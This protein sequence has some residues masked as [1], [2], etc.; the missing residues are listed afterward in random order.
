[1]ITLHRPPRYH[2]T[3]V[4]VALL[5]GTLALAGC[6]AADPTA[7][8]GLTAAPRPDG[9][10]MDRVAVCHYDADAGTFHLITIAAPALPA[11][12]RH[13]DGLPDGAVPGPE[14]YVFDEAC[15][16]I[17][18]AATCPCS[19]EDLG[20][21]GE[22]GTIREVGFGSGSRL[23]SL[24]ISGNLL[25]ITFSSYSE[26]GGTCSIAP[27]GIPDELKGPFYSVAVAET[28]RLVLY[29]LSDGSCLSDNFADSTHDLCGETYFETFGG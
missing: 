15:Q 11:H 25:S 28:C 8:A 10:G 16:P 26:E 17:A 19:F 9:A 23:T 3:L 14:G 13:G 21:G 18:A 12:L 20:E 4:L 1:M 7:D 2:A 22:G 29:D 27:G 5:F 6:D 24:R